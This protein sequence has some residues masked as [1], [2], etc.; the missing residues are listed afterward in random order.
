MKVA[1]VST[2][3]LITPPKKYGGIESVV[4]DLCKGLV[5]CDLSKYTF[6]KDKSDRFLFL[7]IVTIAKGADVAI[8]S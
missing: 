4:Y 1:L 5:E 8:C 2:E 6:K 3:T 7:S